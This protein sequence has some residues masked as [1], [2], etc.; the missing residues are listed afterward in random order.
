MNFD[1][2]GMSITLPEGDEGKVQTLV[3]LVKRGYADQLMLSHD[4]MVSHVN[5]GP[6]P[7]EMMKQFPHWNLHGLH[8][9]FIPQMKEMG[10]SD[11]Q[12]ETMTVKNPA[13]FFA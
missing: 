11:A 8:D 12:I 7:D 3:E 2:M 1:R 5:L 13:K 4:Y 9:Y 6:L 10:V